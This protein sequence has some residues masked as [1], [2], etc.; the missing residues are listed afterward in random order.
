[1]TGKLAEFAENSTETLV[2]WSQFER[3]SEE[4]LS[5]KKTLEVRIDGPY[6]NVIGN[7]E[8]YETLFLIAGGIGITPIISILKC[9]SEP[10][11]KQYV[12]VKTVCLVWAVRFPQYLNWFSEFLVGLNEN[13]QIRFEIL[14]FVT[15]GTSTI[16]SGTTFHPNEKVLLLSDS[17]E[18]QT[19][20]D[21]FN[22]RPN[23]DDLFQKMRD[24]ILLGQIWTIVCGPPTMNEDVQWMCSKHSSEE[25]QFLFKDH[26]FLF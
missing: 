5:F 22:G 26:T 4:K 23:F 24:K 20:T 9:L 18:R 15:K 16:F 12:K 3:K 11:R 6:G 2:N 14:T 25:L 10:Q 7:Y 8:M 13:L 1:L 17:L 19:K 21:F